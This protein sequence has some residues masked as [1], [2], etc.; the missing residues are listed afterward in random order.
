MPSLPMAQQEEAQGGFE[1]AE[2]EEE[3]D[4]LDILPVVD[5]D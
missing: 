4:F 1:D 5:D 3:N 2:E